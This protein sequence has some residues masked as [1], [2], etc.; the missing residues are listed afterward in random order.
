[1]EHPIFALTTRKDT[2][3]RVYHNGDNYVEITPSIEGLATIHDRDVLIFCISQIMAAL[4]DNRKVSKNVRFKAYDL[5]KA[6]NRLVNGQ[7]YAGLKAALERLRGTTII[8]NIVTGNKEVTKGFGLIDSFEVVREGLDGRM[9]DLEVTLSDWVFNAIASQEVL[10]LHRDYFR[11]RKP[12]ERRIYEIARKHVGRQSSWK[13]SLEKLQK[14]TGS[15]GTLKKFRFVLKGIIEEDLQHN[16]IPDYSLRFD[17]V[18]D[19]VTFLSKGTLDEN[20]IEKSNSIHLKQETYEAAKQA[21][22]GWDVYFLEREWL[23]WMD[24]GGLTAPTNPDAAFIGF[25]RKHFER[26]GR[27]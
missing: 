6:T 23:N 20:L 15:T 3:K 12:L 21:A 16:H 5:L 13:I 14:K 22:P 25:C 10:T 17:P 26:H 24:Y 1:M 18:T 7:A 11:L 19:M 4:N 27:P 9:Q 2:K 8:T